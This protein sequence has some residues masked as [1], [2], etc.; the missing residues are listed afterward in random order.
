M[1][2]HPNL[3]ETTGGKLSESTAAGGALRT[4]VSN[5]VQNK[6]LL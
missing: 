3:A 4:A 5:F 2:A 6:L 1:I